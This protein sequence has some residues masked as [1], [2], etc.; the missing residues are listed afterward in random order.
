MINKL[1]EY[2]NKTASP[3][4]MLK[5]VLLYIRKWLQISHEEDQAKIL[6]NYNNKDVLNAIGWEHFLLSLLSL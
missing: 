3:E 1:E 2:M 6:D 5:A 4:A